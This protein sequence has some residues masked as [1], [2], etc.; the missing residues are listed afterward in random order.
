[1]RPC[2]LRKQNTGCQGKNMGNTLKSLVYH[3]WLYFLLIPGVVFFAVFKYIP[4]FGLH[5]AFMD[6]NMYNPSAST[7]VGFGQFVRLFSRDSFQPV[8]FNTIKISMLKLICGFPV[9]VILALMMNEMRNLPF[10]KVTQTLL[11]LPY[12]VSWVILA[13][14]IMNLLDPS[15]GLI[16]AFITKLMGQHLN[17]LADRTAFVP[18]LIITD[19]YKGMGWGTIIYF[20]AMSGIDPQL[21]EAAV[22]DGAGKMRQVLNITLPSIMPTVVIMFILSCGNILNA[23]FDQIFML[24]SA[25]VYEVADIIDTYVY[26]MGIQRN[27]YAFSTAAGM[28]KSAAAFV[29]IFIVNQVAKRSGNEGIF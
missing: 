2:R 28:F 17:I 18:M 5:I 22:I 27:D 14:V 11:Y 1:M 23:G 29:L 20:A 19:I 4:I 10:K 3:R 12:F 8:L 21:Y 9:P 15:S 24:Y 16:T 6:Y 25:Q 13:G 7:W 26:R